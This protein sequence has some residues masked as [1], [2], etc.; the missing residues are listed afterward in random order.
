MSENESSFDWKP[1][2]FVGAAVPA[3]V[4]FYVWKRYYRKPN[5][6]L[7]IFDDMTPPG[8]AFIAP[9]GEEKAKRKRKRRKQKKN[10]KKKKKTRN[11]NHPRGLQACPTVVHS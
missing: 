3:F 6:Y 10:K 9:V 2:A 4:G 1:W 7:P 11:Y 8:M 5:G